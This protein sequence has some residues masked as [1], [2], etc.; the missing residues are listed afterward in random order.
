MLIRRSKTLSRRGDGPSR[1]TIAVDIMDSA[2][3]CAFHQA[4]EPSVPESDVELDKRFFNRM[5]HT[6][7]QFP[8]EYLGPLRKSTRLAQ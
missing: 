4:T 5:T 3:Q 6:V 1:Q 2:E 8:N 7:Q